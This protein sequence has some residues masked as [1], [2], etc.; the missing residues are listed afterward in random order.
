M[1]TLIKCIFYTIE[2]VTLFTYHC[3][4]NHEVQAI[5]FQPIRPIDLVN[6]NNLILILIFDEL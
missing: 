1:C 5:L 2:N 3:E 4:E 6:K